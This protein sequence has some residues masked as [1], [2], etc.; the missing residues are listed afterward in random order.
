MH[1]APLPRAA[2]EPV[3]AHGRCHLPLPGR[4]SGRAPW[5]SCPPG[6][7]THLHVEAREVVHRVLGIKDVFVH[8][9]RGAPRV[10]GVAHPHLADRAVL[11]KQLVQLHGGQRGPTL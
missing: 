6:A 9:V 1:S 2:R 11:A 8:D 3:A 10:L 5:S 7:T 4:S